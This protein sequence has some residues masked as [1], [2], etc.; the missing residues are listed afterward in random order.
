MDPQRRPWGVLPWM[1]VVAFGVSG[2]SGKACSTQKDCWTWNN[3]RGCA[4][5]V[6]M[7]EKKQYGAGLTLVQKAVRRE[8]KAQVMEV[9][10]GTTGRVVGRLEKVWAVAATDVAAMPEKTGFRARVQP[11]PELAFY[12]KYTEALLRRYTHMAMESGRVPSLMGKE[13][14]RAKVTHYEVHGF[15]DVVIF[16]CDMEKCL[17]RLDSQDQQLIKRIALQLYT[18]GEVASMLG[19][20]LRACVVR[21]G[22]ALDKLTK[23]LLEARMLEVLKSCQEG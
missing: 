14:F 1:H 19:I 13:M 11:A 8:T 20:S 3:Y 4:M 18:Q 7:T 6:E 22:Q 23:V 12:R 9:R 17:K 10:E 16:C 5:K 21:Y 15:D 2:A